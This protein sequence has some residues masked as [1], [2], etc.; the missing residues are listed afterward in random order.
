VLI[1]ATGLPGGFR[2]KVATLTGPA[3]FRFR[4]FLIRVL[5]GAQIRQGYER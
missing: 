5:K 1:G 4:F 3:G 2:V